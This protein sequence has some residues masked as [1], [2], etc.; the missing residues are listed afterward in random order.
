[1]GLYPSGRELM[2]VA[3]KGTQQREHF[4]FPIRVLAELKPVE[5]ETAMVGA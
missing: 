2:V 1:M 3:M 4:Q 5:A